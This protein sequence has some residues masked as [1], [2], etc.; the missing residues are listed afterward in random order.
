MPS[1]PTVERSSFVESEFVLPVVAPRTRREDVS[2]AL[3]RAI[4]QGDLPRG[5]RLKEARLAA[6]LQVSRPTLREAIRSLVHEGIVT[7]EPYRGA[8]VADPSPQAILDVAAV[9]LALEDLACQ[10][11]AR[12]MDGSLKDVLEAALRAIVRARDDQDAL[13]LAEAHSQFH[14]VVVDSARNR[15]LVQIWQSLEGHVRL[16]LTVDQIVH[17]DFDRMVTS[18]QSYLNVIRRGVPPDITDELRRHIVDPAVES[19]AERET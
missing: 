5:V 14:R 6:E 17:P 13:S 9:R 1:G 16:A 4:L 2:D 12:Q 15:L 19:A 11:V 8:R 18:H 7:D 3:R 10:T